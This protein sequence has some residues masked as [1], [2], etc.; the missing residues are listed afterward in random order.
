MIARMKAAL[1]A[2]RPISYHSL[3]MNKKIA[4]ALLL[5]AAARCM[6][7][8]GR[9][10]VYGHRGSA[11][12]LPGD[13]LPSFQAAVDAG[14]D[15]LELDLDVTKDGVLVVSHEQYVTP[16]RCLGP[17]GKRLRKPVP[18]RS[19]T[20]SELKKYDCGSLTDPG[21]P[22]QRPA[23]G[24]S[25]P[26]LDEVF[27]LATAAEKTG[28]PD[29]D[30]ETKIVPYA[31]QLSASP[32]EFAR[33]IAAEV[34]KY[35]LKDRVIVQSFD[36]RTLRA[37]GSL[38]PGIR[39]A[40]LTS[41]NLLDMVPVL[42]AEGAAIWSPDARW[43]TPAEVKRVQAA[44]IKVVPWTLDTPAEWDLAVEAGVDGIITDYPGRLADYL[45]L[46]ELRR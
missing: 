32:A 22:G 37:I 1:P 30:I 2:G 40:Q 34:D 17:D 13:T 18:I 7:A 3:G 4:F 11:G 33:L 42:K 14:A 19:L 45:K 15:A 6:A 43:V 39:T 31:P 38:E 12:T 44:G 16:A 24:A 36:F 46:K 23:R 8:P 27:R 25:I 26:T 29:L 21:L 41:G 28:K 9:I 35:G 20:L 10:A 5:L